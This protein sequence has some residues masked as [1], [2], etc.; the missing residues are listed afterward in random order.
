M[1]E[2]QRKGRDGRGR[3]GGK[4]KGGDRR[5]SKGKGGKGGEKEPC[6]VYLRV[7]IIYE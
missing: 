2:G 4:G 1:R 7:E 3:N 6:S 5:V